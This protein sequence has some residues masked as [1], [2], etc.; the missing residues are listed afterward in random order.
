MPAFNAARPVVEYSTHAGGRPHT[1]DTIRKMAALAT[2][3]QATYAIRRLATSVT[4]NVPSKDVRG[5]LFALYAWV[6]DN[7]RYRFDPRGVEWLQRPQ[8]TIYERAGDC[9]DMATLLASLAGSLGHAWRFYTVGPSPDVDEHIA[10]QVFDG[11]SWVTLDPVLEPMQQTTA[12]RKDIGMFART[13]PGHSH[14]WNS[15]G[16]MLNGPTTLAQRQ[17]WEFVPYFPPVPPTGNLIQPMPGAEPT[18]DTRYRS[19]NAPGFIDGKPI[20]LVFS[21]GDPAPPVHL[22]DGLGRIP[23]THRGQP[24]FLLLSGAT[25]GATPTINADAVSAFRTFLSRAKFSK[26]PTGDGAKMIAQIMSDDATAMEQYGKLSSDQRIWV[27]RE[28]GPKRGIAKVAAG[29]VKPVEAAFVKAA[30]AIVPGSGVAVQTVINAAQIKPTKIA[31]AAARQKYGSDA[32]QIFKDGLFFVYKPAKSLSGGPTISFTL[33]ASPSSPAMVGILPT[34]QQHQLASDMV[35]A[36]RAYE[37]KNGKPLYGKG[38]HVTPF[39]QSTSTLAPASRLKEDGEYGPNV[40]AAAAWAL[41][42][43]VSSMPNVAPQY[44]AYPL[45]WKVPAKASSSSAAQ[46][47]AGGTR[48]EVRSPTRTSTSTKATTTGNRTSTSTDGSYNSST[49]NNY[50]APAAVAPAKPAAQKPATAATAK[51][52]APAIRGYMPAGVETVNPGLPPA[53][54]AAATTPKRPSSSSSSSKPAATAKHA[55]AVTRAVTPAAV[56]DA[57][58]VVVAP[59][60]PGMPDSGT[61]TYPAEKKT[62]WITW[63]GLYLLFKDQRAA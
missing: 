29:L 3:D 19:A 39:Q 35:A 55:A 63:L 2:Q 57:N 45:T 30:N 14:I 17:L 10:A 44:K 25:L 18:I 8:R 33:G 22:A 34:A 4:H 53:T 54:A 61:A 52:T 13:A 46:T 20:Q 11:S 5:E 31:T 9:D 1:S 6:R 38:V 51:P 43:P 62:N 41:G 47:P 12:A 50:A 37:A 16:T 56:V 48:T 27:L 59:P 26:P 42:V 23:Y 32:R 21:A 40:Q 24:G 60:F 49:V 7:I 15:E 28:F 36:L 58:G